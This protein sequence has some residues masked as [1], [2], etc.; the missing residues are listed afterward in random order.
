M[1][2]ATAQVS[3]QAQLGLD[4]E[5][6]PCS[7]IHANVVIG[8]RV[9]IGAYCELGLP[10]VLGDGTALIIADDS[11]IRSHAVFYE[12]SCFGTALVTGHH[13]VVRENTR[14]GLR[15]QIGTRTEIQGDCTI[16]DHVRLQSNVFIGKYTTLG[17]YVWVLPHA[18][19]TNDP[20]PP[21]NDLVGCTLEDFSVISAAAVILPT[22]I[23][24]HHALVAAQACVTKNVVPHTVVAGVPARLMGYTRDIL[25]HDGSGRP[26]YPWTTHFRRGYPESVTAHWASQLENTDD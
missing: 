5:I 6:G 17:H 11:L 18:I 14:A 19:L 7:I 21:S 13:V 26:A 16:G 3:P 25:L 8:H 22:I 23:V 2:H 9:H 1:I 24:G 4:V 15:F 10:T 12:S 20:T